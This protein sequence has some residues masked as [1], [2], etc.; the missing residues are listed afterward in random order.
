VNFLSGWIRCLATT[1][2]TWSPRESKKSVVDKT[3]KNIV[4]V[5][6]VR[7]PF[8]MSGT[9]YSKLMPHDLARHALL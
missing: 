8:L 2:T 1:K 4:F 7:T 3:G 5:D 9:D 6:A